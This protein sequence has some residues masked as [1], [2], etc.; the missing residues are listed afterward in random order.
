[1]LTK[2]LS[3][4][5]LPLHDKIISSPTSCDIGLS[6]EKARVM[7]GYAKISC[8][9]MDG[10][11]VKGVPETWYSTLLDA[12]DFVNIYVKHSHL[13]IISLISKFTAFPCE[14]HRCNPFFFQSVLGG[15]PA[16]H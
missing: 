12:N 3:N 10:R 1:M 14:K 5:P 4:K 15:H 2:F 7:V 11:G 13:E 8:L 16:V 6:T 9:P